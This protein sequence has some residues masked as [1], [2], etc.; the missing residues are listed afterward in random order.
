MDGVRTVRKKWRKPG[1]HYD[2][3]DVM[4]GKTRMR[5]IPEVFGMDDAAT[6]GNASEQKCGNVRNVCAI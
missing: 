2:A 6:A 4:I 1:R 3:R 5:I